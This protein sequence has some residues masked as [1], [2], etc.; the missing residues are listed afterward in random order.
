MASV[1]AVAQQNVVVRVANLPL[2]SSTCAMVSSAYTST[3][4]NHPYLKSACEVAEKGIKTITAAALTSAKPIIQKLEPKI[5]LANNYACGSLDR[6]E[7]NLPILYQPVDKMAANATDMLIHAKDS[8]AHTI[9]G[10]MEVTKATLSGSMNTILGSHMMQMVST[11]VNAALNKS[12][13]LVDHYLPLTAEEAAKTRV[14]GFEAA[15]QKP[16]YIRLWLLSSKVHKR[17]YEQ[18]L[19]SFKD[20]KC[21]SQNAI[22]QVSLT[23]GL[24]EYAKIVNDA[25]KSLYQSWVEWKENAGQQD[26]EAPRFEQLELFFLYIAQDLGFQLKNTCFTLVLSI[27]ALPQNIQN[28]IHQLYIMPWNIYQNFHWA[29][30]FRDVSEQLLTSS[31]GQLKKM[32][33]TLDEV[34]NYLGKTPVN[35]LLGPL[36]SRLQHAEHKGEEGTTQ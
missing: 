21:K 29:T 5:A 27:Q 25:Q 35:W 6:I 7:A 36:Y 30:T 32:K 22:A 13:A 34:M 12:E 9:N 26:E 28:R 4:E 20:A 17:T 24:M 33:G 15:T 2:V 8:V 16:S 18:I 31:R 11:G 19:M 14:E 1:A 3:K 23:I 10:V